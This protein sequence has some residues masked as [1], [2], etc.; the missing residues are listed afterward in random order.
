MDFNLS[1]SLT[2]ENPYESLLYNNTVLNM[3]TFSIPNF[4]LKEVDE[5]DNVVAKDD[6]HV[7]TLFS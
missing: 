3:G 1:D 4:D 6:T 5:N 7:F 2:I